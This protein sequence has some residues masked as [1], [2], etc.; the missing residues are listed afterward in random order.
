MYR[1]HVT[2]LDRFCAKHPN[3]GIA[4]LMLYVAIANVAL[5]LIDTFSLGGVTL[6]DMLY[7]SRSAIMNG[8]VW[9]LL[10]FI[11]VPESAGLFYVAIGA[12]FYY[13]IGSTLE[14]EWGTAKFCVFYFSGVVLSII[15]G[16]VAGYTTMHYI[17]LS[18]FFA[19]ATLFGET[20]VLLFFIIPIKM[21]WLAWLDA[22]LFAWSVLSNLIAGYYIYALLPIVAIL[23]YLIFFWR[24]F[25][26]LFARFKRR[27]SPNV[28]NFK[29]AQKQLQKKAQET[30]GY[31]HKCS[32]CGVTDTDNPD[33]EFRYCSKCDGYYCYCMDHINNHVH[34]KE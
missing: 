10:T 9:R 23:N 4:N 30:G 34:I 8:Q 31:I 1:N 25:A 29:K 18:L 5:A 28:V 2:R 17:N 21:K 3:F 19:F 11:L 12:Y 14:R 7:F 6:T 16:M 33:M 27:T 24:D 15:Y 22:A 26:Y 13:W 20:Q 32:V